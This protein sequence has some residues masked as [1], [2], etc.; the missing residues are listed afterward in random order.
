[1]I[2]EG[3]ELARFL[4]DGYQAKS[5]QEAGK[6]QVRETLHREIRLNAE[7][8]EEATKVFKNDPTLSKALL[9]R[10]Q[11]DGFDAVSMA[12]LPLADIFDANWS[13][14]NHPD[15]MYQDW[16]RGISQ[17]SELVERSYHRIRIQQIRNEVEQSKDSRSLGYLRVLLR[18][19]A[20]A[21]KPSV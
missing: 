12:G 21:T 18:K 11:T 14:A 2:K 3:I 13:V 1:M 19:A 20:Q 6:R 9:S 10:L 16:F 7:L 4:R 5:S 17:V 15:L 8:V